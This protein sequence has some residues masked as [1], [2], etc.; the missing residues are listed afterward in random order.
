MPKH[1]RRLWE[2][3]FLNCAGVTGLSLLITPFIMQLSTRYLQLDSDDGKVWPPSN[4]W[5]VIADAQLPA[6]CC[7]IKLV[8]VWSVSSWSSQRTSQDSANTIISECI[9][10]FVLQLFRAM[11]Q[12]Q[13][14]GGSSAGSGAELADL[15]SL[16]PNGR[17]D[18]EDGQPPSS[19]SANGMLEQTRHRPGTKGTSQGLVYSHS[20]V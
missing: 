3:G 5:L 7:G 2:C 11:R 10:P 4:T 14:F 8:K 20:V 1:V 6:H 17:A 16:N 12:H 19:P 9:L 18:L 15:A 13:R